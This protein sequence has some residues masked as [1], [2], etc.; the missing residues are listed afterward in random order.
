[1][2]TRIFSWVLAKGLVQYELVYGSLSTVV[3]LMFW[4]YLISSITLFGAHLSAV[5]DIHWPADHKNAA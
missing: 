1:V 5:I 4:I 2:I 3:A